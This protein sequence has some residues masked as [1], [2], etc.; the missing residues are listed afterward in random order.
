MSLLAR[1]RT[2]KGVDQEAD[3]GARYVAGSHITLEDVRGVTGLAIT[4]GQGLATVLTA[5]QCVNIKANTYAAIPTILYRRKPGGGKERAD[6]HPLA[7]TFTVAANPDMSAF[8]WKLLVKAHIE[9][10]GNHF[11]DIVRLGD[12]SVELWPFRPDRIEA[13][14][15]SRGRKAYDYLHPTDGRK[16]L[17]PARILHLK[18]LSTD[19]L[20]GLAPVTMMRRAMGLYRK[21]E[22]FGEAVF[23]NN[24]RPGVVLSHPK[25]LSSGAAERL[26]AQVD[27]LRGARNSNKTVVLEEGLTVTTIGFPPEDAQFLESRLFQKRELAAG[28][29]MSSGMLNDPE[30]NE[31]EDQESRKFMKRTMVPSFEAFEQAVQLQVIRD[32]ELFVEFLVDAYLRGD[33]KARAD[34][35]AVAWEHG[36]LNGDEWRARENQDPL[37]DGLGETYYRPANWVPLGEDPVA[38]GGD[39]SLGTQFGADAALVDQVTRAKSV[40]CPACGKLLVAELE[41]SIKMACY[42]CKAEVEVAA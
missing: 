5:Y 29:G 32:E 22:T 20:V 8:D 30:A 31:D 40:R 41:G 11:S 39:A 10:W 17:D 6:D 25:S 23:D 2:I 3:G 1:A 24:A 13:Y 34:A 35:Y 37:P 18:A 15:D 27:D 33:P 4:P 19:G 21:A 42:R 26:A 12:G 16:A 7:R 36:A 9:T 28:F 38:V 14:W